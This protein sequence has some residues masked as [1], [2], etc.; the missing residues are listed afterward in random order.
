MLACLA[1]VQRIT[2]VARVARFA[3]ITPLAR[4]PTSPRARFSCSVL[5]APPPS[6]IR[7]RNALSG[8][9]RRG[10]PAPPQGRELQV[11]QRSLPDC[12]TRTSLPGRQ[13][14]AVIPG[15]FRGSYNNLGC[16]RPMPGRRER[17][18]LCSPSSDRVFGG[19]SD[20]GKGHHGGVG[21]SYELY[22]ISRISRPLHSRT[23]RGG[24]A[25]G[26]PAPA[27]EHVHAQPGRH[28]TRV[29]FVRPADLLAHRGPRLPR[30]GR[31]LAPW[32]RA[33]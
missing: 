4:V 12:L 13:S 9:V 14:P 22:A 21:P 8:I 23:T 25:A 17:P 26:T 3:R 20:S 10:S 15:P 33:S 24:T 28:R 32:P 2:R 11:R 30:P 19:R 27:V 7:L 1:R 16:V 18:C 29:A 5:I 31:V 6:V